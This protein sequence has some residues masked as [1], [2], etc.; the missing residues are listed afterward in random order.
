MSNPCFGGGYLKKAIVCCLSLETL[1]RHGLYEMVPEVLQP[2]SPDVWKQTI[3]DNW[4]H[5]RPDLHLQE[6]GYKAAEFTF[7]FGDGMQLEHI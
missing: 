6:A 1:E 2:V 3:S 4:T 5:E 7:L